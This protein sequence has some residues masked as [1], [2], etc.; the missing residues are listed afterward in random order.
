MELEVGFDQNQ[1][2]PEP[3]QHT[4][5]GLHFEFFQLLFDN[6]SATSVGTDAGVVVVT[7]WAQTGNYPKFKLQVTDPVMI[8][9]HPFQDNTLG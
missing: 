2:T 3:C 8:I 5:P 9:T 4:T 1:C 7:Y 6:I